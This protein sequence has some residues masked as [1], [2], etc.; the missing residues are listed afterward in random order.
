M[1]C[2]LVSEN[3]SGRIMRLADLL[4]AYGIATV[5]AVANLQQLVEFEDIGV[6]ESLV[7]GAIENAVP[8]LE[9]F[10]HGAARVWIYQVGLIEHHDGEAFC[11]LHRV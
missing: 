5:N 8:Q 6:F 10:L 1:P 7:L 2:S 9:L 4:Y 3:A 11:S